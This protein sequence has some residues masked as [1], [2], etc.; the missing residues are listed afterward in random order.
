M[1]DI[2]CLLEKHKKMTWHSS[3]QFRNID[4]LFYLSI[5]QNKADFFLVGET[6][7]LHFI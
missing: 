4:Y 6:L 3:H 7:V 1:H 2:T 5:A